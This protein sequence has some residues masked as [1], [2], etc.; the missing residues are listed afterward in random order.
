VRSFD[1]SK[2]DGQERATSAFSNELLKAIQGRF[3]AFDPTKATD[4]AD[5][6]TPPSDQPS[7]TGGPSRSQFVGEPLSSN[8]L[9]PAQPRMGLSSAQPAFDRYDQGARRIISSGEA[10][11]KE[12]SSKS[13]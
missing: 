10:V 2:S 8:N 7:G 4:L 13:K 6:I 3:G 5:L 1:V 9:T 12:R 11:V